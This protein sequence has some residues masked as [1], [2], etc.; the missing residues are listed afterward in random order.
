MP[1]RQGGE[2]ATSPQGMLAAWFKD[3]VEHELIGLHQIPEPWREQWFGDR[4]P[5]RS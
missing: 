1:F 3:A 5:G 4:A 2:A